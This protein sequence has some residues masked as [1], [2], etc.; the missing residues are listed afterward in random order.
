MIERFG[1]DAA[2]LVQALLPLSQCRKGAHQLP[3][4]SGGRTPLFQDQGRPAAACRCVSFPADAGTAHPALLR[5][6]RAAVCRALRG[7]G[8]WASR[9]RI[10]PAN[11]CRACRRTC[12]ANHGC[13]PSWASPSGQR[14]LYDELMLSLHDAAKLDAAFPGEQSHRPRWNFLPEV[15]G[16]C[17]P[18]RCC[19]RRWA[20]NSRWNRLSISMSRK[21]PNRR[22]RPLK[23][24]ERLSGR[25]L[26]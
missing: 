1:S 20:A 8:R 14:S 10:S 18:T 12:R 3:S 25:T 17:S 4:R 24:L 26:V 23:V 2:G 6:C 19:M 7:V 11:S 9:S 13:T 16:W 21:W 5:Q 15:A 22:A